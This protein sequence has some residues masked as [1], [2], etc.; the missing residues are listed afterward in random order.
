MRTL[1]RPADH[2][3]LLARLRLLR[4]DAMPR[5]G[6]LDAPRMVTHLTDQLQHS[7]S[8]TKLRPRR[9][10]FR[11]PVIK[12]LAMYWLPWPKGK[13]R[14]PAAAFVT[15]PG[16]WEEDLATLEAL[17]GRFAQ[18][19]A[20]RDWPAH[21]FFGTMTKSSWARVSYRHFDHHLRQFGV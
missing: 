2:A 8:D 13:I 9:S 4:P 14:A 7:A 10:P 21:P 19:P 6:R 20:E 17:M 5:W 3:A 15:Q 11:Y 1:L 12:Q 18:L 16:E